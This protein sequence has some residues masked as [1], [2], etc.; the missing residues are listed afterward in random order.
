MMR[1]L[2]Q[3]RH[4]GVRHLV[5]GDLRL[6]FC[7]SFAAGTIL[8]LSLHLAQ[9]SIGRDLNLVEPPERAED[10][11]Q[12]AYEEF[13]RES[14]VR[15]VEVDPD[16]WRYGEREDGVISEAQFLQ[17]KISVACLLLEP[18]SN[19]SAAAA[20]DTWGKHCDGFYA[21]SHNLDA[22][23]AGVVKMPAASSFEMLCVTFLD[24][25]GTEKFHWV[26]VV[27][28]DSV[29]LIEN[30]RRL[31]A[32]LNASSMHYLGH[33]MR[34]WGQEY[35]WGEAGYTLSA[36]AAA[37]L[38]RR[39]FPDAAAC[40]S[41]GRFWN[42]G[43]WYLG[44]HLASLGVQP[45]DTRD[46][47]GRGRFVGKSF[48]RLL[49]P[50][51]VSIFERYWRDSVAPPADGPGCCADDAVVLKGVASVSKLYQLEY[52]LHRLRPFPAGGKIGNHPPPETHTEL[53]KPF[54]TWE[55]KAKEDAMEKFLAQHLTTP[56]NIGEL[57]KSGG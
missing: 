54:F 28:D 29:V 1:Q 30:L 10:V 23:E 8:A 17:Q 26:L 9:I 53:K 16:E 15:R 13:L 41:G 44:K 27:P 25:F 57:L 4:R 49:F 11:A 20:R 55:E 14:G 31:V 21:R 38:R 47:K 33:P 34:F 6:A 50:G 37:V 7:M 40:R 32:P 45:V 39:L 3:L 46:A 42:N 12:H 52:L 18:R 48:T 51:A 24:I 56:K 36:G 5:V 2:R 35:N 19:A 22:P 43:D